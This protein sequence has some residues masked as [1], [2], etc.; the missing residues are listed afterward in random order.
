MSGRGVFE[1][2]RHL[3][4][5]ALATE[6][7]VFH[8]HEW[9]TNCFHC[10]CVCVYICVCVCVC[11]C[12]CVRART[13]VCICMLINNDTKVNKIKWPRRRSYTHAGAEM[14]F[15]DSATSAFCDL[16]LFELQSFCFKKMCVFLC[17]RLSVLY[18]F[19]CYFFHKRRNAVNYLYDFCMMF[20]LI[21]FLMVLDRIFICVLAAFLLAQNLL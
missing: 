9:W 16:P 11:M 15:T 21:F 12:V 1:S 7:A 5:L 4:N 17:F 6:D 18:I 13:R 19:V 8:Q 20:S 14:P 2:D 3:L 10:V